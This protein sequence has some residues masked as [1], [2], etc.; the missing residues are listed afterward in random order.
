MAV[1]VPTALAPASRGAWPLRAALA[2]LG[3]ATVGGLLL[4]LGP[5][6]EL[7]LFA[8]GAARLASLL[9]GAAVLRV[10]DGWLLALADRPVVVTA[11]CSGVDYF[12]IV[13]ALLGWQ[14]ARAGKSLPAAVV[15]A[16]AL[17]LPLTILVNALRVVAVTHAHRWVIPLLPETYRSFAHMFT[18]V[19]VFLPSLIALNLVLEAYG[20]SRRPAAA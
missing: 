3:T 4:R 18:G 14:L 1:V 17:A 11:A 20:R 9:T 15:G 5:S 2:G 7:D 13:A 16:V 19:A 8:A 6:L 12:L 10:D